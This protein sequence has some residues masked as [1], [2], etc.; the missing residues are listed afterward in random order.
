[1]F[2]IHFNI[3]RTISFNKFWDAN[4]KQY[5][6]KLRMV[7]NCS[8]STYSW[9]YIELSFCTE[10]EKVQKGQST[11]PQSQQQSVD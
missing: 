6:I 7:L 11:I 9:I 3:S 1:M 10:N 5:E 2:Y 8:S 4:S